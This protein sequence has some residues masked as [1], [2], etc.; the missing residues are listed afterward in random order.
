MRRLAL[1]LGAA[2]GTAVAASEEVPLPDAIDRTNV[3]SHGSIAVHTLTVGALAANC[4]VVV[5]PAR[6]AIVID[7]GAAPESLRRY[8]EDAGLHVAAYVLT[9]SHLDHIS[10][11]DELVEQ[12]PAPVAMHPEENDWAFCEKNAWLPN[13]PQTRK[14][15]ITR[16]L[17]HQ[18]AFNDGGL[19][20][21]VLHTPGHSPG[22]ICLWFPREKVVFT[23]DTLFAGSAGR[24]DLHR[25]SFTSLIRSLGVFLAMPLDTVIYAGHGQPTTVGAE[26]EGNPFMRDLPGPKKEKRQPAPADGPSSRKEEKN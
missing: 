19:S 13:Y 20:Y 8:L 24:T 6:N 11:L 21:L 3:C 2:V 22:S 25:S 15:A 10:A 17:R 4:Y 26:L 14:V 9:H 1:I 16:P 7:P 5:D 12:L 23:G 18:Q